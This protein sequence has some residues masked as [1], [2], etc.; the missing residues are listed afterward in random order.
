MSTH[1]TTAIDRPTVAISVGQLRDLLLTVK[2]ATPVWFSALT[3]PKVNLTAVFHHSGVA[4]ELPRHLGAG[5][6]LLNKLKRTMTADE[7]GGLQ[8]VDLPFEPDH[9]RK[10]STV[11]AMI[12]I[13]WENSVQNRQEKEGEE[14]TFVAKERRFGTHLSP[15]LIEYEGRLYM[16]AQV[17]RAGRP[18]YLARAN[19][20]A[21]LA[22]IAK[23]RIAHFLPPSRD[24]AESERQGVERPVVYRQWLLENV[25]SLTLKGIRYRIRREE[26]IPLVARIHPVVKRP[27]LTDEQWRAHIELQG[28]IPIAN[29]A[30]VQKLMSTTLS[31]IVHSS[32]HRQNQGEG[33]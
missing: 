24:E 12:G 21:V 25:T 23:E 10:L 33:Q 22:Q 6:N 20:T 18:I 32:I 26:P 31:T 17:L 28:R 9:I 13:R 1:P 4:G 7:A 27:K 8:L 29:A 2:G 30:D 16:G 19:P 11:Q 3:Q 5:V 14:R 15:A